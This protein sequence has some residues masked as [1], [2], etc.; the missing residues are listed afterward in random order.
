VITNK[1]TQ[2]N[3]LFAENPPHSPC[4]LNVHLPRSHLHCLGFVPAVVNYLFLLE[5]IRSPEYNAE[6]VRIH[7][8]QH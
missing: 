7:M 4:P 3:L 6:G 1:S 5:S 2:N 8:T